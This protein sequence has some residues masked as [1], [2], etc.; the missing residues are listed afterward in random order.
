[1]E[2]LIALYDNALIYY[3]NFSFL[4]LFSVIIF[5]ITILIRGIIVIWEDLKRVIRI[6]NNLKRVKNKKIKELKIHKIKFFP[7]KLHFLFTIVKN[8]FIKILVMLENIEL[9]A[10]RIVKKIEEIVIDQ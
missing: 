5:G 10:K 3:P 1:M 7:I 8:L 4:I 2:L 9:K 6:K